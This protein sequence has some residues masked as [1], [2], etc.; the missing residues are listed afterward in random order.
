MMTNHERAIKVFI[1]AF[2]LKAA[3]MMV[4]EYG[5]KQQQV[6]Q[7]LGTTQAAISKYLKEKPE[8]YKGTKIESKQLKEFVEKMLGNDKRS[9][10]RILCRMCQ[11]D[12]KFVCALIVK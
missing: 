1:P 8:K 10:Q 3:Q 7:I 5:I 11:A 6:A 12:K 4:N 2:R 9:A